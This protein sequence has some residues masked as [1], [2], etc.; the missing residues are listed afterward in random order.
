MHVAARSSNSTTPAICKELIRHGAALDALNDVIFE[1]LS[2]FCFIDIFSKDGKYPSDIAKGVCNH[3]LSASLREL[4]KNLVSFFPDFF[5]SF[6]FVI[7][8]V[9]FEAF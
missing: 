3:D 8:F 1:V 2:R 5:R 6:F 9:V 4:E 7:L